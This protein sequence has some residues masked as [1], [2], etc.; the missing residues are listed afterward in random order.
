MSKQSRKG[1][2]KSKSQGKR[3]G[4]RKRPLYGLA[5]LIEREQQRAKREGVPFVFPSCG[6]GALPVFGCPTCIEAASVSPIAICRD[7]SPFVI[8]A[9]EPLLCRCPAH[10]CEQSPTWQQLRRAA[11]ERGELP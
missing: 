4:K 10:E 9:A 1:K 11:L 5:L 8:A 3:Q 2:S 7:A 6:H